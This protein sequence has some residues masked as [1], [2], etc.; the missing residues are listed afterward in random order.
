VR[1]GKARDAAVAWAT[2]TDERNAELIVAA[3]ERADLI[4]DSALL[5]ALGPAPD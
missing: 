1:F 4:V 2:G 3:R 5:R